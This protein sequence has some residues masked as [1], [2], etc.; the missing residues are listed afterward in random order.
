MAATLRVRRLLELS[1]SA[2]ETAVALILA[3]ERDV[4]F[5]TALAAAVADSSSSSSS[6][7]AAAAAACARCGAAGGAPICAKCTAEVSGVKNPTDSEHSQ[8]Q[9]LIALSLLRALAERLVDAGNA[10]A[11]ALGAITARSLAQ[12][13]AADAAADAAD[14]AAAAASA[15]ASSENNNNDDDDDLSSSSDGSATIQAATAAASKLTLVDPNQTLQSA[16][17]RGS[18]SAMRSGADDGTVFGEFDDDAAADDTSTDDDY[19]DDDEGVFVDEHEHVGSSNPDEA[20]PCYAIA[21]VDGVWRERDLRVIATMHSPP[22]RR[23]TMQMLA[24][25]IDNAAHPH[26]RAMSLFLAALLHCVAAH[27][28]GATQARIRLADASR[29]LPAGI[30]GAHRCRVCGNQYPTAA[31]LETHVRRR[32][33]QQQQQQQSG[34][35]TSTGLSNS[36]PSRNDQEDARALLDEAVVSTKSFIASTFSSLRRQYPMLAPRALRDSLEHVVLERVYPH[37]AALY[38]HADEHVSAQLDDRIDA[39]SDLHPAVFDIG[40][41]YWP[42]LGVREAP[43]REGALTRVDADG[44]R[45]ARSLG[46][47]GSSEPP[48]GVDRQNLILQRAGPPLNALASY[49]SVSGKLRALAAVG[50]IIARCVERH[51]GA[52][53]RVVLGADDLLPLMCYVII[54]TRPRSLLSQMHAMEAFITRDAVNGKYGYFLVTAT[55]AVDYISN[56]NIGALKADFLQKATAA[57]VK[58]SSSSD[59]GETLSTR[60]KPIIDKSPVPAPAATTTTAAAATSSSSGLLSLTLS[61]RARA[62][63]GAAGALA[64][65]SVPDTDTCVVQVNMTRVQVA[66]FFQL[67]G[68]IGDE[69]V[70]L[71]HSCLCKESS[72][73]RRGSLVVSTRRLVFFRKSVQIVA[74]WTNVRSVARRR[75]GAA[76]G[77]SIE[78]AVRVAPDSDVNAIYTF[79]AFQVTID[80]VLERMEAARRG[81]KLFLYRE[82]TCKWTLPVE[83]SSKAAQQRT[84]VLRVDE[85]DATLFD[86]H[87]K[88]LIEKHSLRRLRQWTMQHSHHVVVDIGSGEARVFT[89]ESADD[90][91][92]WLQFITNRIAARGNSAPGKQFMSD[93]VEHANKTTADGSTTTASAAAVTAATPDVAAEAATVTLSTPDSM[94]NKAAIGSRQLQQLASMLDSRTTK[95]LA[96][97][98]AE[99]LL[100]AVTEFSSDESQA[101]STAMQTLLSLAER[102]EACKPEDI[103]PSRSSSLVLPEP[104]VVPAD[105]SESAVATT[106]TAAATTST[107]AATTSTSTPG[108]DEP[109]LS[110]RAR[111]RTRD[112]HALCTNFST[113]VRDLVLQEVAPVRVLWR[114]ATSSKSDDAS[115]LLDALSPVRVTMMAVLEAVGTVDITLGN[116]SDRRVDSAV[117]AI[118]DLQ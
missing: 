118:K 17:K 80:S 45:R 33:A 64:P 41:L 22:T 84:I 42:L 29:V 19:D 39:L 24:S 2:M 56:L 49:T 71:R 104:V 100:V 106:S 35:S 61:P 11:A 86:S 101:A 102:L 116:D 9:Q 115:A 87:S 91:I 58:F 82:F 92:C 90:L 44:A 31:D 93:Y 13:D 20:W 96:A 67:F 78:V 27:R 18:I 1:R 53:S 111:S 72:S 79:A 63:S 75:S 88:E 14:A 26:G 7:S 46:G 59:A 85:N 69:D 66:E 94:R 110:R 95:H 28:A 99:A 10:H 36:L 113:N 32:H 89:Y 43:T 73:L 112:W 108:G 37:L 48:P 117:D 51:F 3:E 83:D 68:V 5:R 54:R 6:S 4:A 25:W 57:H 8:Q 34:S 15:V 105:D 65:P 81:A 70:L 47:S 23:E 62:N 77:T 76:F 98:R 12:K 50:G 21:V 107:T 97:L 60:G 38:A 103:R 114:V 74:E 40:E 30:G 16:L 55:M 52:E 109:D